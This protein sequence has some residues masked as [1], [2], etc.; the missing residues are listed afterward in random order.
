MRL[1]FII[2][3]SLLTFSTYASNVQTCTNATGQMAST[4]EYDYSR[5]IV[6]EKV[7]DGNTLAD[8]YAC[9]SVGSPNT[10][11]CVNTAQTKNLI[12]QFYRSTCTA[13]TVEAFS[14]VVDHN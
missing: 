11:N 13:K 10:I 4:F 8:V 1:L 6:N 14:G 9:Q 7:N 12:V 5:F 3:V 2:A